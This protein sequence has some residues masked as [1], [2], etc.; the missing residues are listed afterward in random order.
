MVNVQT[1]IEINSS[2]EKIYNV[3]LDF[4]KHKEWDAFFEEIIGNIEVGIPNL[5]FAHL[6][7][8]LYA[9][10]CEITPHT[11]R[12]ISEERNMVQVA[13]LLWIFRKQFQVLVFVDFDEGDAVRAV[14]AF[15]GVGFLVSQEIFVERAGFLQVSD[16]Q[17]HVGNAENV[18][19]LDL[20]G[21]PH[22]HGC[23]R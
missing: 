2:K 6:F 12:R 16:K 11:F 1:E 18:R 21:C 14:V 8:D 5:A 19:A 10:G 20:I 15:Q 22:A 3:L 4:E 9:L 13:V 17:R 23:S 7:W